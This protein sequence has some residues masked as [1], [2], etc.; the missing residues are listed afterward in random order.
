MNRVRINNS[1]EVCIRLVWLLG[2]QPFKGHLYPIFHNQ[3]MTQDDG[4]NANPSCSRIFR[5]VSKGQVPKRNHKFNQAGYS[6]FH[7]QYA[8]RDGALKFNYSI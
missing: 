3:L 7:R 4:I 6:T 2:K 8:I 1:F 5:I